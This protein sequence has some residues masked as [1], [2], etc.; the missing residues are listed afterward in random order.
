MAAYGNPGGNPGNDLYGDAEAEAPESMD[1]GGEEKEYGGATA[2]V[3][4][5]LMGG[6]TFK[7]GEE[8]VMEITRIGEDSFDIKYATGKGDKGEEGGE[9]GGGYEAPEPATAPASS[10]MSSMME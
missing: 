7:V 10:G 5:E 1:E 9:E 3:P 6:K 2:T 4:I 8:I